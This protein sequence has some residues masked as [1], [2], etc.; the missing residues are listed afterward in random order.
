MVHYT[1]FLSFSTEHGGRKYYKN[2]YDINPYRTNVENRV[3]S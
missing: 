2:E 3:S 1:T